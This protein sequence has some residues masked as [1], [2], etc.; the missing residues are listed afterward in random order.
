MKTCDRFLLFLALCA[1]YSISPLRAATAASETIVIVYASNEKLNP[2]SADCSKVYPVERRVIAERNSADL[3]L[4]QLFSGLST[5]E[6]ADQYVSIFQPNSSDVY[7][8]VKVVKGY[9]YVN[10]RKSLRTKLSAVSASCG[11]DMFFAQ[12]EETLKRSSGVKKVFYA[13]EKNP[14]AFYEWTEIGQCP[15][16]LP[17]CSN[18]NF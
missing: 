8:S 14:R 9:A 2:G 11:R 5:G 13:I 4:R 18:R 7:A 10:L 12:I 1:V 6:T 3:A 15:Q 16:E 17:K